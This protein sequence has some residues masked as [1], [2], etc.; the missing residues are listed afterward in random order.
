MKQLRGTYTVI[1]T[2]FT[3]DGSRINEA[4]L[5]WLVDF[6]SD[7]NGRAIAIAQASARYNRGNRDEVFALSVFGR[8]TRESNCD[9]DRSAEASLLQTVYL[10]NDQSVLDMLKPG[11]GGWIPSSPVR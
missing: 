10:Q 7:L 5:R 8:S 11:G 6:Q 3:D 2:P 1:V 9:C 4:M